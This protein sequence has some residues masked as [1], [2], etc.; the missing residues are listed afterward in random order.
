MFDTI[1]SGHPSPV[2]VLIC[3]LVSFL[4]GA[5][6]ALSAEVGHNRKVSR[7]VLVCLIILPVTVQWVIM[8]VNGSIGAGVAVAGTFSLVRFRSAQGNAR[9]I[10]MIFLAMA[11]GIACGMGYVGYAVL[12]TLIVSIAI[13]L[14]SKLNVGGISENERHLRITIPED[15][16]YEGIFDDIFGKF[17]SLHELTRT[18]TANMGTLYELEYIIREKKGISEKQ[19][20]DEIR[21]RNGNLPV[22]CGRIAE[23]PEEL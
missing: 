22:V 17:T 1:I 16:D 2:P 5:I 14:L 3:T 9:D 23:S 13:A 8:M 21:C 6:I 18:R 10:S 4:C 12:F 15:L 7:N 19:M 11:A 20:I